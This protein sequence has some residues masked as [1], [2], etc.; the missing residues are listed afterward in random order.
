MFLRHVQAPSWTHNHK[1]NKMPLKQ[2]GV[3]PG[4]VAF[5]DRVFWI[6]GHGKGATYI[7]FT[8]QDWENL[9]IGKAKL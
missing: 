7:P 6:E 1:Q 4:K 5:G 3:D 8:C 2:E 9:L